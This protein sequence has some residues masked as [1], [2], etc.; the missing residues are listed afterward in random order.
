MTNKTYVL[1]TSSGQEKHVRLLLDRMVD[2]EVVDE[3]FY[4][5]C[6]VKKCFK[7]TWRL[8]EKK[9]TPGYLYVLSN[10]IERV[11]HALTT[12]PAFTRLLGN[13]GSFTPLAK[14]E[15]A[16]IDALTK[17]GHRVIEM[18]S[19]VIEHDRVIVNTGPLQGL[20]G[21]IRK[22]DR[23]KRLACLEIQMLGRVKTIVVGLEIVSKT[24]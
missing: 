20:E 10:D 22:I 2:R 17:T 18:S 23:H 5:T 9:L 12:I 24:V 19:G 8:V 21:S 16:W 11:S 13:D 14:D 4:P 6:L 1:Q 3:C 15:T 7:G